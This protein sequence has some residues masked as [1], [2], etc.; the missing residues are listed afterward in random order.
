M[1][2]K[3]SVNSLFIH[4]YSVQVSLT[5]VISQNQENS[6]VGK[7]KLRIPEVLSSVFDDI[8]SIAVYGTHTFL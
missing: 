6:V 2:L 8:V 3:Y 1:T 4:A 7:G 5:V